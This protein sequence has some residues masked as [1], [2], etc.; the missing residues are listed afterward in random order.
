VDI[1][2]SDGYG[3]FSSGIKSL[4]HQANHSPPSSANAVNA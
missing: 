2:L 4:G 3:S 1:L